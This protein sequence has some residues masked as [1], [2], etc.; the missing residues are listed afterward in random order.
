MLF[1]LSAI[2]TSFVIFFSTG[3]NAA[4]LFSI[5]S[6]SFADS[7][8]IPAWYSCDGGEH[9]PQLSWKGA[10]SK[11]K[12][13]VLICNDPDAP[14]GDWYH[15]VMYNIPNT[16]T[17]LSEGTVL[18]SGASLGK[19][20][21]GRLQYNGPCPPAGS[22]HHYYFTLYALDSSL[23]LPSGAEAKTVMQAMQGHV[24]GKTTIVGVF[25]H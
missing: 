7:K 3:A 14:Q 8:A 20:S 13:Y 16:V 25:G 15:W 18:A 2:L 17:T 21:W 22:L 9:S 24:V 23:S 5:T 19:N 10:P 1:P 11:T 6:S 12:T 4:A